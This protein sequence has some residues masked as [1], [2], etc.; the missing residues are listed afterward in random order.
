[1][2][3]EKIFARA[4]ERLRSLKSFGPLTDLAAVARKGGDVRVFVALRQDWVRSFGIKTVVDVGSN[5]GQFAVAAM[6]AF[7]DAQIHCFEPLPSCFA[8]L[9]GRLGQHDR[10]SLHNVAVADKDSVA[11]MRQSSFSPS[12]SLMKMAP[13]HE[14]EFP[15][16]EGG[17]EVEVQV[18]TLDHALLGVELPSPV[19]M[20]IDT[21]GS[22]HR[23]LSGGRSVLEKTDVAILETSYEP[24]YEG[25]TFFPELYQTM[26]SAGFEFRG[27]LGELRSR[28]SGRLLQ[29]DSIFVRSSPSGATPTGLHE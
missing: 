22:E 4:Y 25:Q 5:V 20:K 21:Q 17:T 2:S 6:R 26:R 3:S 10:V 14:S 16:T 12:S 7:P 15:F 9:E 29:S 19:L 27:F 18:T 13:L 24:L 1:M 28:R 11:M 8:T 23:V